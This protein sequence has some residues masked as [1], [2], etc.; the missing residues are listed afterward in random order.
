MKYGHGNTLI[1]KIVLK[2]KNPPPPQ[3]SQNDQ[4]HKHI[5]MLGMLLN[6]INYKLQFN[7]KCNQKRFAKRFK[8]FLI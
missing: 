6:V 7:V 1:L 8:M 5:Y 3:I 2:L 4:F